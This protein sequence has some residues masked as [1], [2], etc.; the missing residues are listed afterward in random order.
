MD[1]DSHIIKNFAIFFSDGN[2]SIDRFH[3]EFARFHH[4]NGE[5]DERQYIYPARINEKSEI[6][7]TPSRTETFQEYLES[8][9]EDS[10]TAFSE[11]VLRT[12][13]NTKSSIE[14]GALLLW[15]LAELQY[16]LSILSI[17]EDKLAGIVMRAIEKS[18]SF[19]LDSFSIQLRLESEIEPLSKGR[20]T[21]SSYFRG[22][23]KIRFDLQKNEVAALF[24]WLIDSGILSFPYSHTDLAR[25]LDNNVKYEDPDKGYVAMD[26]SKVTLSRLKT[27]EIDYIAKIEKIKNLLKRSGKSKLL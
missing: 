10:A 13:R 11:S 24:I 2:F 17:A 25:F 21:L 20:K 6:I 9:L 8:H 27:E 26:K 15:L 3:K 1:R 12:V 5:K 23:E 18:K 19:I 16:Y 7:G 22:I 14:Q 4:Y